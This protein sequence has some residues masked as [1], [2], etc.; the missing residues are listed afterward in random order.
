[1]LTIEV[2]PIEGPIE[3]KAG[4]G[5]GTAEHILRHGQKRNAEQS[6]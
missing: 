6:P 4:M 2:I 5:M 1:M 3:V